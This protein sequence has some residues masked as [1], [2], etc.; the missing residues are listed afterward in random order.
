MLLMLE[1][2]EHYTDKRLPVPIQFCIQAILAHFEKHKCCEYCPSAA[3]ELHEVR[4][5]GPIPSLGKLYRN[6]RSNMCRHNSYNNDENQ[7]ENQQNNK[8]KTN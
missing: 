5:P 8:N 3:N 6:D 2:K 7:K 1:V 4:H